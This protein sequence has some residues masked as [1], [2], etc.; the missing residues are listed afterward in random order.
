MRVIGKR[1]YESRMAFE[2]GRI[3]GSQEIRAPIDVS[4]AINPSVP[5]GPIA[6]GQFEQLVAIPIEVRLASHPRTGYQ[7]NAFLPSK[8]RRGPSARC[9]DVEAVRSRLHAKLKPR[10]GRLERIDDLQQILALAKIPQYRMR[11]GQLRGEVMRSTLI[12]SALFFVALETA[13]VA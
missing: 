5:V 10:L 9:R 1:S 8:Y 12:A 2:A 13:G 7:V 3:N 4:G 11:S 6:D